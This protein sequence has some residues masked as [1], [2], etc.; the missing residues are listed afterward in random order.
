V[1]RAVL[2]C[3]GSV[4]DSSNFCV[5]RNSMGEVQVPASAYFGA[6]TRR[7]VEN[8]PFPAGTLL[9]PALIQAMGLV[10]YACAVV[11]HDLEKLTRS[12][13][14]LSVVISLNPLIGY[15]RALHWPRR[16]FSREKLSE[17]CAARRESC[18]K[19]R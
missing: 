19:P 4:M 15:E 1:V 14:N 2:E 7:T 17:N 5:E 11:N 13:K 10:K 8:F 12:G 3:P 6:Q 9:L 18:Q 16:P